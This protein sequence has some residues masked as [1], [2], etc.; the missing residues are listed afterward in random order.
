MKLMEEIVEFDQEIK[1]KQKW[2]NTRIKM[3]HEIQK[4]HQ[5]PEM[6]QIS[7]EFLK[8]IQPEYPQKLSVEYS[9]S[10]EAIPLQM[11]DKYPFSIAMEMNQKHPIIPLGSR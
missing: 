11:G 1:M 4:N 6:Q 8:K 9:R 3:L 7:T 10:G 2:I 5:K